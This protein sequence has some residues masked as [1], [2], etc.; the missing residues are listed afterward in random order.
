MRS[1]SII[2]ACIILMAVLLAGCAKKPAQSTP[3]PPPP[4]PIE[5]PAPPTAPA[6]PVAPPAPVAN[7]LDGDLNSVNRYVDEQGL[8]GDV[9]FDYDRD[10]LR[11]DARSRL[12]R[13]AEFMK[14]HEQ[15]VFTVEGHCDERGSIG[16]NVALGDRRASSAKSYVS[17]LG[18]ADGRMQTV[19]YGKERPVCTESNESC[20][21]RNRR[22]HFVI[23]GRK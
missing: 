23:T 14:A 6:E 12:Q 2:A 9:H 13:N 10:E 7:P 5:A 3:P 22:A 19:T 1:L 4:A 16:Y 17:S 20:W 18:V 11:D 21:S 8:I 15:F